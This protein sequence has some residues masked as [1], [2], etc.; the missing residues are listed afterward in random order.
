MR[1]PNSTPNQLG[2]TAS[3][4]PRARASSQGRQE[5][6]LFPTRKLSHSYTRTQV[7]VTDSVTGAGFESTSFAFLVWL[8]YRYIGLAEKLIWVCP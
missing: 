1:K 6:F 3:S 4:F 8:I 5:T 7:L 2:M